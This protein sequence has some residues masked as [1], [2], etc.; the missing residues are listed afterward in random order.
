VLIGH[1]FLWLFNFS[2]ILRMIDE[3]HLPKI[4]LSQHYNLENI[5]PELGIKEVFSKQAD[6]S[7]ITGDKEIRVA[8]VRRETQGS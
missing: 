8:R 5:L 3:F 6:L 2:F 7:G 4:S 1:R